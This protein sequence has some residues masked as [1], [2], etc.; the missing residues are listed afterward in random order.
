MESCSNGKQKTKDLPVRSAIR[1][2]RGYYKICLTSEASARL[3]CRL[4]RRIGAHDIEQH[5]WGGMHR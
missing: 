4:T 5:W 2:L 1:S 3:P